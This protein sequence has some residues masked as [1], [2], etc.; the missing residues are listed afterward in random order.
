MVFWPAQWNFET[1]KFIIKTE[2]AVTWKSQQLCNDIHCLPIAWTFHLYATFTLLVYVTHHT[3]TCSNLL[4]HAPNKYVVI[5]VKSLHTNEFDDVNW[6]ES[7]ICLLTHK[8]IFCIGFVKFMPKYT[9]IPRC[10]AIQN[11]WCTVLCQMFLWEWQVW[12]NL[13]HP[14]EGLPA[15]DGSLDGIC[16]HPWLTADGGGKVLASQWGGVLHTCWIG[17]DDWW[18]CL[19]NSNLRKVMF[20][21]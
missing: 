3:G 8:A 13:C 17:V 1:D 20:W 4:Y 10:N 2:I 14:G 11:T 5:L 12:C 18:F 6:Q 7:K 19:H 9:K 15:W 16:Q 21:F